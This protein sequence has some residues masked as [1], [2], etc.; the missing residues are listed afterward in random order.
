MNAGRQNLGDFF[1]FDLDARDALYA[2]LDWRRSSPATTG[3]T[4]ATRSSTRC[5]PRPTATARSRAGDQGPQ[6]IAMDDAVWTPLY[7]LRQ[8][9]VTN[10]DVSGIK[11]NQSG[12]PLFYRRSDRV[13]AHDRRWWRALRVRHQ[14][15]LS[16]RSS[17]CG[18][19]NRAA[20]CAASRRRRTRRLMEGSDDG[21]QRPGRATGGRAGGSGRGAHRR[22]LAAAAGVQ[23]SRSRLGLRGRGA[24][25]GAHHLAPGCLGHP[26]PGA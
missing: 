7:D 13:R 24:L 3:R 11:V 20:G 2:T 5:W 4:T 14:R 6:K 21:G 9:W 18:R 25:G 17:E 23:P 22:W 12:Y 19:R 26:L 1:Y 15:A 10:K 8:L 16:P